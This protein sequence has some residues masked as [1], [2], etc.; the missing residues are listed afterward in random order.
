MT[1]GLNDFG[2]KMSGGEETRADI[3][4]ADMVWCRID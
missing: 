2:A 4:R 1:R 3:T